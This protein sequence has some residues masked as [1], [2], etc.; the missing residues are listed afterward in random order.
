M[1]YNSGE[2]NFVA[3]LLLH[4]TSDIFKRFKNVKKLHQLYGEKAHLLFEN[5]G[6]NLKKL[7]ANANNVQTI[8][9][10]LNW[11]VGLCNWFLNWFL[12]NMIPHVFFNF[13]VFNL[14]F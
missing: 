12:N 4:S 9:T 10:K 14:N 13:D 6:D 5:Q 11:L 3:T 7:T 2:L 8:A 1:N